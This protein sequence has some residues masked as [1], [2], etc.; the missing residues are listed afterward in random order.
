VEFLDPDG[1]DVINP[2][3]VND[4]RLELTCSLCNKPGG[5]CIQCKAPR[6]LAAFHASCARAHGM[7]MVEKDRNKDGLEYVD[8]QVFCERHRPAS[9]TEGG[10]KR[11]RKREIKW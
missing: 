6:C 1:R 2:F 4:K 10:K 11:R 8:K 9:S 7:Y 3:T 5:A